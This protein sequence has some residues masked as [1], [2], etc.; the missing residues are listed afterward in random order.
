M[1]KPRLFVGFGTEVVLQV[2]IPACQRI[3]AHEES[4]PEELCVLMADSDHRGRNRYMEADLPVDRVGYSQLS[5]QKV[6]DELK[7]NPDAFRDIYQP[8]HQDMLTAAPD[9]GACMLPILGR[10]M[11]RAS[12]QDVLQEL[13]VMKRHLGEVQDTPPDIFLVLNPL[14]GTSRGSVVDLPRYLRYLWPD[15]MITVMLIYPVGLESMDEGTSRIYQTNFIEALRLLEYASQPATYELYADPRKGWETQTGELVNNILAFDARYG[16]I[17]LSTNGSREHHLEGGLAELFS[18]VGQTL[19]GIATHDRLSDWLMGRLS[20]VTLHRAG[21]QIEGHR[22]RVHAIHESR[23]AVA[24][25]LFQKALVERAILSVLD[26]LMVDERDGRRPSSSSARWSN[27]DEAASWLSKKLKKLETGAREAGEIR[28]LLKDGVREA[29]VDVG[30][31]P[32]RF[33]RDAGERLRRYGTRMRRATL[34]EVARAGFQLDALDKSLLELVALDAGLAL[35][36]M[37]SLRSTLR[38]RIEITGSEGTSAYEAGGRTFEELA[39]RIS[40]TVE[41]AYERWAREGPGKERQSKLFWRRRRARKLKPGDDPEVQREIAAAVEQHLPDLEASLRDV[42][43]GALLLSLSKYYNDIVHHLTAFM[44]STNALRERGRRLFGASERKLRKLRREGAQGQGSTG[45]ALLLQDEVLNA[46]L[47]RLGIS[48]RGLLGRGDTRFSELADLSQ[49]GFEEVLRDW[50]SGELGHLA[51]PT[52]A[53]ALSGMRDDSAY[54]QRRLLQFLARTQPL[55]AFNDD[56]QVQHEQG[57]RAQYYVI[58]ECNDDSLQHP[59]TEACRHM[60]LPQPLI[61]VRSDDDEGSL[62]MRAMQFVAGLTFFSQAERLID[63]IAAH[64]EVMS[65]L[66]DESSGV[67]GGLSEALR[68]LPESRAL[69]DLLPESIRKAYREQLPHIARFEASRS[70]EDE[71]ASEQDD[72]EVVRL[73]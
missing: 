51:M 67:V 36:I 41:Q 22:T 21:G 2:L 37:E 17:R 39:H 4:W 49:E 60:G 10:L 65:G 40:H 34:D 54:V 11:L 45:D 68:D 13:Q 24:A 16:N 44:Q 70:E 19:S 38:R 53:E 7:R 8:H 35:E 72:A 71:D 69:P 59:F 5:L 46:V 29:L 12:R 31:E 50:L 64:R 26:P 25:G 52:L 73:G 47:E 3:L 15:A 63:M 28:R 43:S 6:R 48:A 62:S 61:E 56:L 18:K 66:F 20:D 55:V 57:L 32:L 14:S 30:D 58:A 42:G 9:N 33:S 23:M 27:G 1:K